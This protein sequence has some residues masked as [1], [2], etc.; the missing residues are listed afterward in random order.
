MSALTRVKAPFNTGKINIKGVSSGIQRSNAIN[1][2]QWDAVSPASGPFGTVVSISSAY[3]WIPEEPLHVYFAGTRIRDTT[4][5]SDGNLPPTT[6]RT[7]QHA[8]G[9]VPVK[10]K[11]DTS[12]L[13]A[14]TT[15]EYTESH[16]HPPVIGRADIEGLRLVNQTFTAKASGVE[17]PDGDPVTLHYAWTVNDAAA[18]TDSQIF[19]APQLEAGDVLGVTISTEDSEGLW[20]GTAT[21]PPVTLDWN[22]GAGSGSPGQ[23]VNRVRGAG[24]GPGEMVDIHLDDQS[25]PVLTSVRTDGSG[26]FSDLSLRLPSPLP[27]GPHMLF[28]VGASSG[29]VGPGTVDV[30]PVIVFTP[31]AVTVGQRA[32]VTGQGFASN[33]TVTSAFP[34]YDGTTEGAGSDGSLS[35][36]VT[37][38]PEPGGA[39]VFTS[40][41]PSGEATDTITIR[42]V[43]TV[44]DTAD[45]IDAVP[46]SVSGFGTSEDVD[47]TLDSGA[48][49]A[50]MHTDSMGSATGPMPIATTFGTHD[51]MAT[52][53]DSGMSQIVPIDIPVTVTLTPNVGVVGT[54]VSVSSS[55]GWIPGQAVHLT[56]GSDNKPDLTADESGSVSGT[57]TVPDHRLGNVPITLSDDLLHVSGS[58]PFDLVDEPC[59]PSFV[60]ADAPNLPTLM[61]YCPDGTTFTFAAGMYRVPQQLPIG[62][63]DTLVG[64]GSGGGG[65]EFR[66]SIEL[67]TES[68]SQSGGVW[69]HSGDVR[70]FD[71]I[72]DPCLPGVKGCGI[73]DWVYRDGAP[74]SRALA[75]CSDLKADEFCVDYDA[76]TISLGSD[77]TGHLIEY[78][79]NLTLFVTGK[80]ANHVTLKDFAWSEFGSGGGPVSVS[81]GWVLDG[82]RAFQNHACGVGALDAT[83]EA[84]AVIKNSQFDHNGYHGL[85][86]YRFA[87]NVLNNDIFSNNAFFSHGSGIR[88]HGAT[89]LIQGNQ[90][91]DNNGVGI[92]FGFQGLSNPTVGEQVIGNMIANNKANGLLL[93]HTCN[94][95][96]QGNTLIG[97]RKTQV[98]VVD[99]NNNIISNNTI[100]V[101]PSSSQRGGV[102]IDG[103]S[104]TGLTTV[105]GVWN[106]ATSNVVSDN[107]ITMGSVNDRRG[108]GGNVNGI[109]SE[110]GGLV[111]GNAFTGNTYHLPDGD[112]TVQVW[113]WWDGSLQQKVPFSTWQANAGQDPPPAA[114][115]A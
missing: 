46:V 93:A 57:L 61:G 9:P 76:G 109:I 22:I 47:V 98:A 78:T 71:P 90:I 91:H 113:L 107:D 79:V 24:F 69:T 36:S 112:C 63:G 62:P 41:A 31:Q 37:V 81:A 45:P 11:G 23:D 56:F 10:V 34:G 54:V 26:R 108:L 5:D 48:P 1:L 30:I 114:C 55:D 16:G 51:V 4:A 103:S 65:T 13:Q 58:A 39:L 53:V 104:E 50:T 6:Y 12:G 97:N 2:P 59:E 18:G 21:A 85:C 14:V 73:L 89:G 99:G 96:I 88:L 33:E 15:Y 52:G 83:P 72:P 28:G 80:R 7:P 60:P 86:I 29:I 77:P 74:L 8:L 67:G 110:P 42:S 40:S 105:C 84:P 25:G 64:A 100:V 27:G 19:S 20:G 17:D 3:G 43:L 102:L 111:S 44:P 92:G 82:V 66:G 32:T 106:D 35:V 87:I 75:P 95:V 49:L 101:S 38:P 94:N 70:R 115:G 68:F